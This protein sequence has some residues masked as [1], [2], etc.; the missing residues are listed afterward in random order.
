MCG[1]EDA[2]V[3]F[4]LPAGGMKAAGIGSDILTEVDIVIS[5]FR[6]F[7]SRET[8]SNIGFKFALHSFSSSKVPCKGILSAVS[9][10]FLQDFE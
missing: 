2:V 9:I 5:Y 4:K 10:H 3:V 1:F 8:N 7:F 6:R